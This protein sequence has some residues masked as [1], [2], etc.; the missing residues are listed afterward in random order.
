M[1]LFITAG[2]SYKTK[3]SLKFSKE[4]AS[5]IERY[6]KRDWGDLGTED[7]KSNQDAIKNGGRVLAAYNTSEGKVYLITSDAL[8]EEWLTTILFA[9]EY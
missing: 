9:S 8:A 3:E 4:I 5:C 6:K 2:I 7:I 1:A